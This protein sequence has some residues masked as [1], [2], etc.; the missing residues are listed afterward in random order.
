MK[1]AISLGIVLLVSACTQAK[2]PNGTADGI[3]RVDGH[4]AKIGFA[5]S[6]K[7]EPFHN[8]P[9]ID[10][11]LT[12]KDSSAAKGNPMFWHDTYGGAVVVTL[13]K[14][15]DGYHVI[16]S[17]FL[18]PALKDGQANGIG[19]VSLKDAKETSGEIVGEL[20]TKPDTTVFDQ[21][22]EVDLKFKAPTPD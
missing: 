5:R 20:V 8:H 18:H 6:Y 10:V 15:E 17:T 1:R 4:D 22:L 14:E 13:M 2:S 21:K 3:Y 19:F 12:E 16:G 7:G 11:A 9:T